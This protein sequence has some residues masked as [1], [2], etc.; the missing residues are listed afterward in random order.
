MLITQGLGR[1]IKD[2]IVQPIASSTSVLEDSEKD[3]GVVLLDI[4]GG[5][6][7]IAI[8]HKKAIKHTKVI[9]IAG[10]QVT[11]DIRESLGVVT[12]EAEKLKKISAGSGGN[13][14]LT[15]AAR[16]S[17]RFARALV[18]NTLEGQTL[19][20]EAFQMLGFS[21]ISTFNELGRFLGVI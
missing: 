14:Y 21:K 5:T 7:D 18:A 13:F 15:Q 16:V 19:Y 2:Y 20:R 1:E 4:G 10:N 8:Y 17:K 12:E 11:N 3:L 6:T 9:G